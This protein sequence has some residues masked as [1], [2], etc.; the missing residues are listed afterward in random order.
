M[1]ANEPPTTACKS[2]KSIQS[3]DALGKRPL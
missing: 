1:I 3:L 2:Q